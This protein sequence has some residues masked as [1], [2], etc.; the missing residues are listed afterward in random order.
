M[1]SEPMPTGW[2]PTTRESQG[3]VIVED[4]SGTPCGTALAPLLGIVALIV[5]G[6][7]AYLLGLALGGVK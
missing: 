5:L 6:I 2:P 1:R 7:G 3:R 4:E